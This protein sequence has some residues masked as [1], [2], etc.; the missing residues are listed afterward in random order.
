MTTLNDLK[1]VNGYMTD[2]G[3]DDYLVGTSD[4]D[5]ITVYAGNDTVYAGIGDDYIIDS[6][7][8]TGQG[9]SGADYLNGGSG[10]D[11]ILSTLDGA[12]NVY[13]GNDGIDMLNLVPMQYGVI[14]DLAQGIAQNRGTLDTSYLLQIENVVGTAFRDQLSGDTKANLLA[15]YGNDDLIRGHGGNDRLE[16]DDGYDVLFGGVDND[17]IYGGDKNDVLYGETGSDFLSGDSG[18]DL[19]SGGL[20]KDFLAGGLG[21]DVFDIRALTHS[22]ITG[23]TQDTILDFQHLVDDIDVSH[24]DANAMLAGNQAFVFK[25][26]QAFTGAGQVRYVYD[27]ANQDTVVLFNTDA[28]NA[29]EMSIRIDGIMKLSATDF[30]L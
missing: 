2:T 11:V 9:A 26:T 25:G 12:N 10:D 13:D 29:A 7:G 6:T 4:G 5:F 8:I 28:D 15:G 24:I 14:V 1:L 16:G 19:V 27:Q 21:A 18:N 22:G 3:S 30:I 20:G 23:A 17:S